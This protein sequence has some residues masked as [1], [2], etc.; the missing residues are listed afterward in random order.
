MFLYFVPDRV[1]QEFKLLIKRPEK[2]TIPIIKRKLTAMINATDWRKELVDEKDQVY[3]HVF[4]DMV[5]LVEHKNQCVRKVY[6]NIE[7]L[8]NRDTRSAKYYNI[9][10]KVLGLNSDHTDFAPDAKILFR[11]N[12]EHRYLGN[13]KGNF[14]DKKTELLQKLEELHGYLFSKAFRINPLPNRIEEVEKTQRFLQGKGNTIIQDLKK[15]VNSHP[16]P[17]ETLIF[18]IEKLNHELKTTKDLLERE[19]KTP[20]DIQTSYTFLKECLSYVK[21]DLERSV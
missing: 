7:F 4:H 16:L 15:I 6:R 3:R 5:I 8:N 18:L 10:C 1:A 12:Q 19:I 11:Q 14:I 2:H 13:K 21:Y 17:D 20:E 9:N